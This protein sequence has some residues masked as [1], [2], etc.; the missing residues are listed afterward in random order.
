MGGISGNVQIVAIS[1]ICVWA[2]IRLILSIM[3]GSL[4]QWGLSVLITLWRLYLQWISELGR[5]EAELAELLSVRSAAMA[6]CNVTWV[7]GP[8]FSLRDE[9]LTVPFSESEREEVCYCY[10]FLF[11]MQP[12]LR[13]YIQSRVFWLVIYDFFPPWSVFPEGLA[14]LDT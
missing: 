11:N 4:L 10:S 2:K 8:Q 3:I 9:E 12:V 14:A 13:N 7:P 6:L 5:Q 1:N